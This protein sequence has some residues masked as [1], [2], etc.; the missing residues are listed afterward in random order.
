MSEE[1][2]K[3]VEPIRSKLFVDILKIVKKLNLVKTDKDDYNHL[4][5]TYDLE[6]LY[7]ALEQ[8]N[9]ILLNEIQNGCVRCSSDC[10]LSPNLIQRAIYNDEAVVLYSSSQ[11][12]KDKVFNALIEWYHKHEC[13][14]GETLQQ[15]DDLI[16][17]APNILS[18]IA[19]DI[20]Q[21]KV[22][23]K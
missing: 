1:K 20:I 21:F 17:D 3:Y 19:D 7:T 18:E 16:L 13:Y 14:C 2:E 10:S 8:E 9:K 5:A 23:W 15:L 22:N 11:E 6:K 4:S 12:I